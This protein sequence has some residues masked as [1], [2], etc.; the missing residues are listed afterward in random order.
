MISEREHWL[1]ITDDPEWKRNYICDP[2]ICLDE[3]V[4]AIVSAFPDNPA[5]VLEI[6]CGYGR[7]TEVIAA[8]YPDTFVTGIDVN[9][10]VLP[11]SGCAHYACRD[12]LT[13]LSGFDAIYSVAVFQHLPDDEKHAYITQAY[14]ALNPGGVLRVQFIEGVRDI[15]LDH[16]TPEDL[17]IDWFDDAGFDV[18]TQTGLVHPQWSWITGTK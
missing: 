3:T 10:G 15:Y 8:G 13:G 18:T 5:A 1:S 16:W 12:N 7:L 6:G 9:H 2:N 17:M 11:D 14:D 4:E